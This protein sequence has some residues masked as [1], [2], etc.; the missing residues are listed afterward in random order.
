MDDHSVQGPLLEVSGAANAY[1]TCDEG[2]DGCSSPLPPP[3]TVA[4]ATTSLQVE[5]ASRQ[6]SSERGARPSPLSSVHSRSTG[7]TLSDSKSSSVR[8]GDSPDKMMNQPPRDL[9]GSYEHAAS[10]AAAD[11]ANITAIDF[12][13]E[14]IHGR[15]K[16]DTIHEEHS[17]S[18]EGS[19]PRVIGE[20]QDQEMTALIWRGVNHTA[21]ERIAV[22]SVLRPH[23]VIIQ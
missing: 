19:D 13:Y 2:I 4:G 21:I 12:Q 11:E 3:S 10:H 15:T 14:I 16:H 23:E 17:E 22:P 6:G 1:S 18:S 7:K 5:Q 9:D 20:I 8:E